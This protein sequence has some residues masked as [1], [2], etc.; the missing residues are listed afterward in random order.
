MHGGKKV[1]SA[2]PDALQ[3][4]RPQPFESFDAM[5]KRARF[6]LLLIIG[7]F[8]AFVFVDSIGTFDSRPYF[9]VPHGSHTHYVPKDCDPPLSP[10]DAPTREPGPGERIT[11]QGDIVAAQDPGTP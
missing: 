8:L 3:G 2:V 10:G 5:K 1:Q 9:E 11:C 6:Y 7:L 4:F